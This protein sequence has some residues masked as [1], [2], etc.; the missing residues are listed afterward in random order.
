MKVI[1]CVIIGYLIGSLSPSAL[2]A[3]LKKKDL[4]SAGTGNLGATNTMLVFGKV[5]G[6]LVV[7]LDIGKGFG[8]VKLAAWV[9]P[10]ANW[11]AMLTGFFA[12][13]GHCFPFYLRFK[14]GKGLAT[15]GGV[16]LAFHW[17]LFVFLLLTGAALV[18]LFNTGAVITYYAALC[19][20]LY[21]GATSDWSTTVVCILLS[22]FMMAFFIPNLKRERQDK[23]F[24]SRDLMKR[25]LLK[26]DNTNE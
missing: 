4:R 20:P 19:F 1:V 16:V 9:A 11:L 3:K 2:I 10:Q 14:G 24:K 6:L 8:A 26:K 7:L 13:I 23:R 22:L 18:V 12:V 25:I 21:I 17:W 5:W 15:Y